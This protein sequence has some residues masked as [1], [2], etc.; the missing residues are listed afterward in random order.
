MLLPSSTYELIKGEVANVY[1]QYNICNFPI[2]ATQ[3]AKKMGFEVVAYS[4]LDSTAYEEAI[5][6]SL[7]GFY[8]ERDWKEY[9]FINDSNEIGRE[10]KRMTIFHEI[11]HPVLGHDDFTPDD[12]VKESEAKFFGKYL[13]APS[14][15]VHLYTP[16]S[17]D[18]IRR[19]FNISDK[20]S[21][22]V[23]GNY[24]DWKK[25]VIR[26]GLAEYDVTILY[27]LGV[28]TDIQLERFVKSVKEGK[29]Y[30]Q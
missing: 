29:A 21:R 20:A 17:K 6:V 25:K 19:Y 27:Q 26:S 2:C 13:A 3:L 10:R 12:E 28:R 1:R 4:S 30:E 18:S 14:P 11:G 23:S 8:A 16:G 24:A 9:I 7:D 15:A 5:N 22:I